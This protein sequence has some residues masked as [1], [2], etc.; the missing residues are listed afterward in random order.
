MRPKSFLCPFGSCRQWNLTFYF[1]PRHYR[2]VLTGNQVGVCRYGRRLECCYGWMKNSKGQCEGKGSLMTIK[3]RVVL[4]I[5]T[6]K[7]ESNCTQ[8]TC[9]KVSFAILIPQRHENPTRLYSVTE[10][11]GLIK[12]PN[13]CCCFSIPDCF[14]S[15]VCARLQARRVCW[16]Q[17]MQVFPRIHWKDM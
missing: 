13:Y 12:T 7:L 1:L 15:S 9:G 4:W 3:F 2:Q 11:C 16:P 8:L 14:T 6:Y 5:S 10:K 17:Q